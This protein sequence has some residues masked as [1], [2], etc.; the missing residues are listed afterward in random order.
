MAPSPRTRH[1]HAR[2]AHLT[3]TTTTCSRSRLAGAHTSSLVIGTSSASATICRSSHHPSTPSPMLRQANAQHSRLKP[4]PLRSIGASKAFVCLCGLDAL[5]DLRLDNQARASVAL[6]P[7]RCT[8]EDPAPDVAPAMCSLIV[9][10]TEPESTETASALSIAANADLRAAT[11]TESRDLSAAARF[12][13][14]RARITGAYGRRSLGR[15]CARPARETSPD[16]SDRER[17]SVANVC[18]GDGHRSLIDVAAE[19]LVVDRVRRFRCEGR[20]TREA[21]HVEGLGCPE[22][23]PA[24]PGKRDGPLERAG[25]EALSADEVLK[26]VLSVKGRQPKC[27]GPKVGALEQVGQQ[28]TWLPWGVRARVRAARPGLVQA[29]VSALQRPDSRIEVEPTS[30]RHAR[31]RAGGRSS[32]LERC[33]PPRVGLSVLRGPAGPGWMAL[34]S[35]KGSLN[36]GSEDSPVRATDSTP[37][38]ATRCAA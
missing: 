1:S 14:S 29:S 13:R 35:R 23:L 33:G 38:G 10:G 3:P 20:R 8:S 22:V 9:S 36:V 32:L 19:D 17:L 30:A 6:S 27:P 18:A 31:R 37:R 25:S 28:I 15:D 12:S 2:S 21:D 11:A 34:R 26:Q 16:G 24:R 5:A 4:Q 7:R